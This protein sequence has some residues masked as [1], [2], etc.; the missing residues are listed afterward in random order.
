MVRITFKEKA[1]SIRYRTYPNKPNVA[2]QIKFGREIAE[3]INKIKQV[4]RLEA[5]IQISSSVIVDVALRYFFEY[6]E[7]QDEETALNIVLDGA[8]LKLD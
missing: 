1:D 2:R 7:Q 3:E 5:D 8:F 6:L 4:V